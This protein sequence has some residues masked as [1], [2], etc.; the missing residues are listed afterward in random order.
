MTKKHKKIRQI[1]QAKA[2]IIPSKPS[3]KPWGEVFADPILKLVLGFIVLW[4]ALMPLGNFWYAHRWHYESYYAQVS[5]LEQV[6]DQTQIKFESSNRMVPD[7]VL[8]SSD[9]ENIT[10]GD[11]L[12]VWSKLYGSGKEKGVSVEEI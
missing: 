7:I 5:G 9:T 1:A 6:G 2:V 11:W 8:P 12:V 4:L 3:S 10:V